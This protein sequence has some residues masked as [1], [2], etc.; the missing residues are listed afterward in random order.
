M[1]ELRKDPLTEQWVII[2]ADRKK[3]PSD[4]QKKK[5]QNKNNSNKDFSCP[6]C[7]GNEKLTPPEITAIRSASSLPD[8]IGWEVRVVPNKFPALHAESP[9][10]KKSS[11]IFEIREGIGCHEVVIETTDHNMD[12]SD[13]NEQHIK[14]IISIYKNRIISL[15]K[16]PKL[17]YLM[18]FKNYGL[19]AGAS[20]SHAHSQIIGIPIIPSEISTRIENTLNYLAKE[21]K[22]LLCDIVKE[23]ISHKN[24]I[25][26]ENDHFVAIFPYA[27]KIA[28]EICILPKKHMASFIEIN[29][30][31]K[32][33]LSDIM[34]QVLLKLKVKLNNPDY[35]FFLHTTPFCRKELKYDQ[36]LLEKGFHWY[37][38]IIPRVA[39][40]GGFELGSG[41]YINAVSPESAANYFRN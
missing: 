29:K 15:S 13:Y 41:C 7:L 3:R 16:N 40:I 9:A 30:E 18:V 33:S 36:V 32:L 11:S 24:R 28:F 22:C 38:Q 14:K 39:N 26:I 1:S 21:H 2:S 35:N 37:I 8:D 10:V 6:F 20:L 12:F 23:E 31:K 27:S 5:N 19:N 34:K 25:I 4:F 17:Q